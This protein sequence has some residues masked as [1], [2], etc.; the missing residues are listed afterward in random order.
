MHDMGLTVT[1]AKQFV[2]ADNAKN[3][4]IYKSTVW[5][6]Y[7]N[8]TEIIAGLFVELNPFKEHQLL[9]EDRGL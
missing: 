9:D 4:S 2:S 6:A 5:T 7:L 8:L 3:K 1:E